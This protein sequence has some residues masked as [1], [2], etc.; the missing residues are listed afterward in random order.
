MVNYG[1][2]SK[3]TIIINYKNTYY[4]NIFELANSSELEKVIMSYISVIEKRNGK[5]AK[6][7]IKEKSYYKATLDFVNCLKK[8]LVFELSEIEDEYL[9]DRDLFLKAFEDIYTFFRSKLKFGVVEMNDSALTSKTFMDFDKSFNELVLSFYRTI[10]EKVQGYENRVYRQLNPASNACLLIKNIKWT[11]GQTYKKLLEIPFIDTVMIRSPLLVHPHSN[12]RV[13]TFDEIFEHP[14]A[15][16]DERVEDWYCYPAKIGESLAFVYFHRDFIASGISLANLFELASEEDLM[17]R[18]PDLICLFGMK[19]DKEGCKFYHDIKNDIYIGQVAYK[20]DAEYFGYMKKMCLTLH[21]LCMMTK[22]KLPIHGAMV[23]LTFKNGTTKNVAFLGDSGAGKSETIEALRMISGDSIRDMDIIFDDMGAFYVKNG[24][25]YANGTEIGAFVRLDDLE[26]GAAYRDMD[27]SIFFNPETTNARVVIP[28]SKYKDI[29]KDTKVDMFLYANNYD[30]KIGVEFFT[31]SEDAKVV[32]E[33]GK[34]KA[35]GT[36]DEKGISTTFFANP[37]GPEQKKEIAEPLIDEIFNAF[38]ES[39]IKVGQIY[40]QLGINK[41]N[42]A[43]KESASYLLK[44]LN[45]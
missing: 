36:T 34:R 37:F 9:E 38:F 3:S 13:G 10:G 39:N 28:V 4:K 14:M 43:I 27:R 31:R 25:V 40:T 1:E 11:S 45:I 35:L 44:E 24:E 2:G 6:Y 42:E 18:K 8:L 32:F 19:T 12:K 16:F 29:I 21:N 7:L 41:S 17:Y 15:E 33:E 26:S 5:I 30:D 23:A 20:K 22:K